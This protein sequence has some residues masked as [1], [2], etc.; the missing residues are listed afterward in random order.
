MVKMKKTLPTW[1][2]SSTFSYVGSVREGVNIF[3]KGLTEGFPIRRNDLQ[4]MLTKFS[5]QEVVVGAT[6]VG[7]WP[8]GSL[9]R[10][11]HDKN[12]S[13]GWAGYIAAILIA[14]GFAVDGPGRWNV[15]F[16][17]YPSP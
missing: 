11:H 5:G 10:W 17:V 12:K 1:K 15:S 6:R 13:Y 8:K 4:E 7:P 9:G 2:G 3:V 16:K 14:E